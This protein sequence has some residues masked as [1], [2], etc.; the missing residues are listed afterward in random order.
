MSDTFYTVGH[1]T[2]D[3]DK[4]IRLIAQHGITAL[5][6]VR[7]S[8]Y[9]RMNPQ[10]NRESIKQ[11]LREHE[12]AYVFLGKELGARSNDPSSYVSGKVQ[13]DRLA[14]TTLFASGLERVRDSMKTH[15]VALMCAEKDPLACHRTILVTRNLCAQGLSAQHILEDGSVES[16]DQ[17]LSRLLRQLKLPEADMFRSREEWIEEAYAIQGK[18]IAYEEASADAHAV[19]VLNDSAT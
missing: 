18:R 9:S 11:T 2:H 17:A 15:K 13:Y 7:S 14:K 8:P 6:D 16:H 10:F 3:I 1:S 4:F 19:P 5:C 12:I